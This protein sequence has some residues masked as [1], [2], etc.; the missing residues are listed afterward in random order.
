V[1]FFLFVVLFWG[2]YTTLLFCFISN[3]TQEPFDLS[4][5]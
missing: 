5:L 4:D 3:Q 2:R 1:P